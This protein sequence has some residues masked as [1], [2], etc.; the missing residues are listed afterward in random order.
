VDT[1]QEKI[2]YQTENYSRKL[3][4]LGLQ[5]QRACCPRGISFQPALSREGVAI[6]RIVLAVAVRWGQQGREEIER[7]SGI[8]NIGSHFIIPVP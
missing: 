3:T 1:A 4:S 8:K 2:A 7:H 5:T 6:P